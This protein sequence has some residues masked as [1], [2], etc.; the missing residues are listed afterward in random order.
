MN[1]RRVALA[2]WDRLGG[3]LLIAIGAVA[4]IVGWLGVSRQIYP[5]GQIPYIVS[6]G[7]G[8]LCSV[9]LGATFLVAAELRDQWFEVRKL[10]DKV[11]RLLEERALVPLEPSP[12][13]DPTPMAATLGS[14]GARPRARARRA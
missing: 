8:G 6:G 14:N 10:N 12:A 11:D 4:L 7:I 2:N 5:A 9:G 13:P 3:W 1:L